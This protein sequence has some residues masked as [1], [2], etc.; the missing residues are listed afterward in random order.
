MRV[1]ILPAIRPLDGEDAPA[2]ASRVRAGM[3]SELD[4]PLSEDDAK[5]L[6]AEYVARRR[7]K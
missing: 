3:A 6:N 1:V 7:P 4:V 5:S 2:F